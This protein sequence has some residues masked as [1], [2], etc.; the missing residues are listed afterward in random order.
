MLKFSFIRYPF[1]WVCTLGSISMKKCS[2]IGFLGIIISFNYAECQVIQ[3]TGI[4]IDDKSQQPIPGTHIYSPRK[5]YGTTSSI[6]GYFSLPVASTDTL[7]ISSIGYSN[8][9]ITIPNIEGLDKFNKI[10]RLKADTVFLNEVKILPYP[11]EE[12][13]V[14]AIL[15][16]ETPG[17][18]AQL[19]R[20]IHF[21]KQKNLYLGLN[22]SDYNN[23][24][25]Y[26]SLLNTQENQRVQ[27]NSFQMLNPFA[28]RKFLQNIK[29]N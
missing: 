11:T 27:F 3:F 25:S 26:Q 17:N 2:I 13:F 6:H 12:L 16:M 23:F 4:V 20:N 28:W 19:N 21:I 22:S 18:L 8:R 5:G 9:T 1:N 29:S 7:V 15:S 14:E 24:R 10:I